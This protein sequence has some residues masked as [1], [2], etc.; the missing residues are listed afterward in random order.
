MMSNNNLI[1]IIGLN[2]GRGGN[3]GDNLR[4]EMIHSNSKITLIQEPLIKIQPNGQKLIAGEG[5]GIHAIYKKNCVSEKVRAAIL[6]KGMPDSAPKLLDELSSKDI[7]VALWRM[8]KKP[9]VLVSCY[10]HSDE[11]LSKHLN[12]I[13]K[14]IVYAKDKDIIIHGDFNARSK[15]LTNDRITNRRGSILKE[16]VEVNQLFIHDIKNSITFF[17]ATK[18]QERSSIIDY[19]ITNASFANQIQNW[20]VDACDSM[21]DHRMIKFEIMNEKNCCVEEVL[22][23]DTSKANWNRFHEILENPKL[24]KPMS[25]AEIELF[26]NYEMNLIA[27]AC[28]E[29]M[30]KRSSKKFKNL[31]WSLKLD[32]LKRQVNRAKKGMK[33]L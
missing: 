30:P 19:T 20:K 18:G 2:T 24:G 33:N 25:A 11:D 4:Q 26:A 28:S 15:I 7:V 3:C 17:K 22:S 32:L 5:S 31:W 29:S 1:K 10:L 16:W 6:F 14:A 9:I 13:K 27:E 21:S 8:Y 12:F 23:F